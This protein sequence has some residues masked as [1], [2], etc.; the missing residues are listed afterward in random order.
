MGFVLGLIACSLCCYCCVLWV[1]WDDCLDFLVV[2]FGG[3][4]CLW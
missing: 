2:R 4:G 3:Y 1:L